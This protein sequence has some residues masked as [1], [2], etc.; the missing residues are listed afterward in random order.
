MTRKHIT[1]KVLNIVKQQFSDNLT[2]T[3]TEDS[4][5]DELNGDSL[6]RINIA[7]DLEEEFEI[8]IIDEDA[9]KWETIKDVIDYIERRLS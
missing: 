3:I 5:F 1:E 6:D 2:A 8:D 9:T 4:N 7:I